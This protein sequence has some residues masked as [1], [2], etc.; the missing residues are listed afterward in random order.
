[1]PAKQAKSVFKLFKGQRKRWTQLVCASPIYG[2]GGSCPVE[3]PTA[4]CWCLTGA[5]R[6]TYPDPDRREKALNRLANWLRRRFP[7]Q[8]P[9]SATDMVVSWNDNPNRTFRQVMAAVRAAKV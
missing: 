6:K 1:M 8:Y 9:C 7:P 4:V 2:G 5:L 3:D